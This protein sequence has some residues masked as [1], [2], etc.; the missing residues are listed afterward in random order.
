[1]SQ[2]PYFPPLKTA[3]F[4]PPNCFPEEFPPDLREKI[5]GASFR[6]LQPESALSLSFVTNSLAL[7]PD[8]RGLSEESPDPFHRPGFFR[9]FDRGWSDGAMISRWMEKYPDLQATPAQEEIL[10]FLDESLVVAVPWSEILLHPEIVFHVRCA[11][12]VTRA[13]PWDLRWLVEA[14]YQSYSRLFFLNQTMV[15][16]NSGVVPLV[17]LF[18][19]TDVLALLTKNWEGRSFD[20]PVT[21]PQTYP[22]SSEA[23]IRIEIEESVLPRPDLH[24]DGDALYR[25]GP[26]ELQ[27]AKAI[28]KVTFAEMVRDALARLDRPRMVQEFPFGLMPAKQTWRQALL[29]GEISHPVWEEALLLSPTVLDPSTH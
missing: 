27:R 26:A 1:M 17:G 19:Q 4:L 28:T 7:E 16:E 15:D 22:K 5:C 6:F 14:T 8:H 18:S 21:T 10:V 11:F 25:L 3:D 20:F 13:C 29:A 23:W 2:L 9:L 24:L 12:A